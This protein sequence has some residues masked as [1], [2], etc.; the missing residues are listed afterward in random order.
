MFKK[1]AGVM[2]AGAAALALTA[3]AFAFVDT[4]L[5]AAPAEAPRLS[6]AEVSAYLNAQG[7]DVTCEEIIGP[8]GQCIAL[9]CTDS[10]GNRELRDCDGDL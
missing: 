3:T 7:G 5:D 6:S 4:T 8:F 1:T 10:F 9:I 2:A